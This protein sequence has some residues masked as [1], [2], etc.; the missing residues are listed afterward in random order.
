ME[1]R[2]KLTAGGREVEEE[3]ITDSRW[4]RGWRREK[5]WQQVAERLGKREKLTAGGREV[6]EE[7]K[8]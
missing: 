4:K 2:E 8:S 6:G 5:N 1:K 7:R 3:R